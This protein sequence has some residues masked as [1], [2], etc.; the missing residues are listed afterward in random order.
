MI[1]D[2]AL[3]RDIYK[4]F[5]YYVKCRHFVNEPI[6]IE[7]FSAKDLYEKYPLSIMGAYNYLI[8][9]KED[10]ENALADLKAGLPRRCRYGII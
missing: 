3:H 2:M 10:T 6:V 7:G 9:L 1:R 5:A 4:E 8:Y